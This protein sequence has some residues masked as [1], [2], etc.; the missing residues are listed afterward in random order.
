MNS[1]LQRVNTEIVLISGEILFPKLKNTNYQNAE[2]REILQKV[3][4]IFAS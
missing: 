4:V 2:E 1:R 3:T